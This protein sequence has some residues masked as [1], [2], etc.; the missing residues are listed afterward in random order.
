MP[1][2]KRV[3][4]YLAKAQ[5]TFEHLSHKTVYTAYDL[6]QTLQ[7]NL[8][9]IGKTLLVK[10]DKAYVLVVIPA[11]AR[12]NLDKLKKMLKAKTVS[13]APEKIM[14]K[15]LRVKAGALTAFGGL[16]KLQIV[17]DKSLLKTKEVILQAG[18][19]TDS[20]R[21]KVKDFIEL[22]KAKLG[23]IAGVGGYKVPKTKKPRR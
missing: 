4:A 20:I 21:M 16:H 5:K 18:S 11:S 6:A 14:V 12:L 19:F 10:A 1:L 3:E 2:P 8:T 22:E 13:L 7:R 17:V 15:V 9:E 23:N